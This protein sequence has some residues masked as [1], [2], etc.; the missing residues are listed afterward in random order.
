MTC[1]RF[2]DTEAAERYVIGQMT[3]D[4]QSAFEEH[5]FACD[6]CFQAVQAL[7]DLQTVLRTSPVH[8]SKDEVS[9]PV[10]PSTPVAASDGPPPHADATARPAIVFPTAAPTPITAGRRKALFSPVT[11]VGL[12]AAASVLLGLIVWQRQGEA[13]QSPAVIAKNEPVP[14]TEQPPPI[15]QTPGATTGGEQPK[16]SAGAPDAP[17]SSPAGTPGPGDA[18]PQ[19]PVAPTRPVFD[20]GALA[21][22][23]PPAYVPLQTRGAEPASQADAFQA[24]MA[25]YAA[26]D[27]R[28]AVHGLRA[29]AEATPTDG[30]TQFF[31]GV[32]YLMTNDAAAA[33]AALDRAVA[34]GAAPFATEAHFYLAKAALRQKDLKRAE[35]ELA[36]AVDQEAGPPGEAPRLL[37]QVRQAAAQGQ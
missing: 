2:V 12:A 34:S 29:V 15:A 7:Q 13:P 4:E 36:A 20:L 18:K 37:R 27:Y 17:G 26:K 11:W 31:L 21:M 23:V 22:V 24:A 32:S 16:A 30:R 28:A 9:A 6:E 25:S 10:V 35:R 19:T 1:A 33:T 14:G 3:E 8:A 5:Y